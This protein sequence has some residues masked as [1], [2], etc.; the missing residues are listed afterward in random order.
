MVPVASI[1]DFG[2]VPVASIIDF[3]MVPVAPIISCSNSVF[4]FHMRCM[5]S[6]K[7]FIIIIIIIIIINIS[8]NIFVYSQTILLHFI[9]SYVFLSFLSHL[10]YQPL[11]L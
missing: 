4:A 5:Y 8:H 9:G 3:E 1:I 11:Q 10:L 7:D 2:M 6:F